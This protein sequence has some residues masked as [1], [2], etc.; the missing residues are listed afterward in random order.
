VLFPTKILRWEIVC[1]MINRRYGRFPNKAFLSFTITLVK[2][3]ESEN[4]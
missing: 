3:E 2:M 1:D 4:E